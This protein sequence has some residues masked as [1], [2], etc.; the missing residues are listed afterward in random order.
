MSV[1]DDLRTRGEVAAAFVA[2]LERQLPDTSLTVGEVGDAITGVLPDEQ[3]RVVTIT[4]SSGERVDGAL[5]MVAR[6][7]FAE[8]VERAAS[9]ELLSTSTG[10]ALTAALNAL[11]TLASVEVDP[12]VASETDLDSLTREIGDSAVVV[13]PVVSSDD[14]VAFLAVTVDEKDTAG[15]GTG[16]GSASGAQSGGQSHGAPMV[17]ADVEMGVTA[18]LGRC[19]M[20]VRELLS[21]T[22]GAIIDLD[23]SAGALVDVLV[24]GTLIARGEVVVIDEEFG[25]R[26]SELVKDG[27]E[28]S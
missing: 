25:I 22:P 9:D 5:A 6:R 7:Q 15:D 3:V 24:N 4:F 19:H 16:D 1:Q 21:L 13:Y 23:R 28:R 18:E 26:I 10:L 17:L 27:A 2:E 11:A 8:T 14:I 12:N 20:T